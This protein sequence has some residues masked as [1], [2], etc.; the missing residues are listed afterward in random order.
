MKLDDEKNVHAT[1]GPG[2]FLFDGEYYRAMLS[3]LL[4]RQSIISIGQER[5]IMVLSK[6]GSDRQL[7]VVHRP[8]AK[9]S[10]RAIHI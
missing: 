5:K 10:S 3:I 8:C 2:I 6:C 1:L 9:S 7:Y 4:Q